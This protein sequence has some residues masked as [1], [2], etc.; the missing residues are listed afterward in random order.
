MRE[1]IKEDN[2]KIKRELTFRL[3]FTVPFWIAMLAVSISSLMQR[4]SKAKK[5][6]GKR[7]FENKRGKKIGQGGSSE[8][9]A[10]GVIP[11]AKLLRSLQDPSM[12]RG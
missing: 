4:K 12:M 9:L 3:S 6:N 11:S 1:L 8:T 7:R 10:P 2:I 5:K